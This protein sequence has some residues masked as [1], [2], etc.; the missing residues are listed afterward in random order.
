VKLVS[1][2]QLGAD[3]HYA[4]QKKILWREYREDFLPHLLDTMCHIIIN[5]ARIVFSTEP[6]NIDNKNKFFSRLP[7]MEEGSLHEQISINVAVYLEESKM[8][9]LQATEEQCAHLTLKSM[10]IMTNTVLDIEEHWKQKILRDVE[11]FH[12]LKMQEMTYKMDE[13]RDVMPPYH[14]NDSVSSLQGQ[15][16]STNHTELKV[17]DEHTSADHDKYYLQAQR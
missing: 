2:L 15:R 17:K 13:Q 8:R 6:E 10:D 11:N 7:G 1:A 5:N 4:D 12:R 16:E 9:V 14:S 3:C